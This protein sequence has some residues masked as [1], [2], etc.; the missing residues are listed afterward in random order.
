MTIP[1]AYYSVQ[2]CQACNAR[3]PE[4]REEIMSEIPMD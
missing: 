1:G 2:L 4:E 3:T